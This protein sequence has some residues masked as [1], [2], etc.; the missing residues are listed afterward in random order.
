MPTFGI[1]CETIQFY[2]GDESL[3]HLPVHSE[4][5][6]NVDEDKEAVLWRGEECKFLR[7]GEGLSGSCVTIEV[8][9]RHPGFKALHVLYTTKPT[10]GHTEADVRRIAEAAIKHRHG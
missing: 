5:T 1:L 6:A 3:F 9:V 4:A 2:T 8:E 10:D 7:F